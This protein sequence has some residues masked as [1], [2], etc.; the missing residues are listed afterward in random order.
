MND[1]KTPQYSL[2]CFLTTHSREHLAKKFLSK[3]TYL[4]KIWTMNIRDKQRLIFWPTLQRTV[5]NYPRLMENSGKFLLFYSDLCYY[6]FVCAESLILRSLWPLFYEISKISFIC[7]IFRKSVCVKVVHIF[8]DCASFVF[9]LFPRKGSQNSENLWMIFMRHFLKMFCI[10]FASWRTTKKYC[11]LTHKR[12]NNW[13]TKFD[14]TKYLSLNT[15]NCNIQNYN[16]CLNT[17]ADNFI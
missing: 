5:T 2:E 6:S 3:E 10:F 9:Y 1:Y 4:K 16:I 12:C 11:C 8:W 14:V 7:S 13:T 17:L 15:K